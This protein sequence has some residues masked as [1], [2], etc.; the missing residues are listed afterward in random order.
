[1]AHAKS[2]EAT[3]SA[4]EMV[5]RVVNRHGLWYERILNHEKEVQGG[6]HNAWLIKLNWQP[7]NGSM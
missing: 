2:T 5:E 3:P 6:H 7:R 4:R 1:M